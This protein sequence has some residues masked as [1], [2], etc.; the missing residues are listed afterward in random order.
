MN[1]KLLKKH[2]NHKPSP[3]KIINPRGGDSIAVSY[4]SELASLILSCLANNENY[5]ITNLKLKKIYFL[6]CRIKV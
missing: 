2:N 3:S 1:K 4:D 6:F 5:L